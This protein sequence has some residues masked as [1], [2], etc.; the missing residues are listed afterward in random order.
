MWT[1]FGV[2]LV[3]LLALINFS[4]NV[5]RMDSYKNIFQQ[6]MHVIIVLISALAA[7]GAVNFDMGA[8]V[9][10]QLAVLQLSLSIPEQLW[11]T[12]STTVMTQNGPKDE[13]D[14]K[15]TRYEL[16]LAN[17]RLRTTAADNILASHAIEV[18]LEAIVGYR[19]TDFFLR[20]FSDRNLLLLFDQ[21]S[22]GCLYP[23]FRAIFHS[24]P[25][26]S[27]LTKSYTRHYEP[28]ELFYNPWE[29]SIDFRRGIDN[30]FSSPLKVAA[31]SEDGLEKSESDAVSRRCLSSFVFAANSKSGD[32]NKAML[33]APPKPEGVPLGIADSDAA[34]L[35]GEPLEA[36][37]TSMHDRETLRLAFEALHQAVGSVKGHAADI[38]APVLDDIIAVADE[39]AVDHKN[40]ADDMSHM[41]SDTVLFSLILGLSVVSLLVLAALNYHTNCSCSCSGR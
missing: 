21:V 27:C 33:Q 25:S 9:C 19:R 26:R 13:P 16:D 41:I 20:F 14:F 5:E 37:V 8:R 2:Y 30:M 17:T 23:L 4:P 11:G 12:I 7:T 32:P 1:I 39:T 40:A 38:L 18:S 3:E 35:C 29:S 36:I 22:P 31:D 34:T 28:W 15:T 24:P 6:L 10:I